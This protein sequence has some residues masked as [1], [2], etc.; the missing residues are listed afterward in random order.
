MWLTGSD[1]S[2]WCMTGTSVLVHVFLLELSMSV[3]ILKRL[4]GLYEFKARQK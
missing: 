3:S 4:L 1:V 2:V